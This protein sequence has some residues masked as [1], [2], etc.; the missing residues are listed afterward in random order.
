MD[1]LSRN[2]NSESIQTTTVLLEDFKM[3]I[4]RMLNILTTAI[5]K[6]WLAVAHDA[7]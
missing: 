4:I 2:L 3:V 5:T 1:H 6:E 7:W